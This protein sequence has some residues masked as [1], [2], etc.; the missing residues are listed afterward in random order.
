MSAE[1]K[2][3]EP[4]FYHEWHPTD[5]F[6]PGE[7]IE[8]MRTLE[9]SSWYVDK[10]DLAELIQLPLSDLESRRTASVEAEKAVFEKMQAAAQEWESRA[11]QTMLLDRALE[12][13]HMI[14]VT[15]TANEWK[16]LDGGIWE[17]SNRVYKMRYTVQEETDGKKK[18]QWCATWGIAINRPARPKTEKHYFSGDIMVV[19][20]KKKYYNAEA[21]ARHYIQSRFDVYAHLFTELSPPIPSQYK[22]HFII[23]GLLLPGYT[24]AP[25]ERPFQEVASELLA[26]LDDSDVVLSPSVEPKSTHPTKSKTR[27]NKAKAAPE[28]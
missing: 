1:L 8:L 2:R 6:T 25:P 5:R 13:A 12:Y 21:E 14:E 10:C 3:P 15:H 16:Q 23:N 27:H 28:R 24:V 9:F 22:H 11:V 4:T 20:Q 26:L 19:E 17:I 18:G 7:H